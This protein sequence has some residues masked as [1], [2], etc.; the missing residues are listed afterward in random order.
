MIPTR[1]DVSVHDLYLVVYDVT[2]CIVFVILFLAVLASTGVCAVVP[3]LYVGQRYVSINKMDLFE[4][5]KKM[6]SLFQFFPS[7]V[8]NTNNGS[9][10]MSIPNIRCV[11]V[12]NMCTVG[13]PLYVSPLPLF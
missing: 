5:K 8:L 13:S 12:R 9:H 10:H 1:I 7:L 11:H 6:S 2:S 3:V 4:R